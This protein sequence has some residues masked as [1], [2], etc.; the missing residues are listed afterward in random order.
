MVLSKQT[1]QRLF[2]AQKIKIAPFDQSLLGD[3]SYNLQL[4]DIAVY[5]D[6]G[7]E[8]RLGKD[9]HLLPGEFVL[10]NTKEYI[11]LPNYLIGHISSRS[12][13]ARLGLL[14]DFGAELIQPG[15]VGK[16]CLEI[17]NLSAKPVLL[18]PGLSIAQVYFEFIDSEEQGEGNPYQNDEKPEL[19]RLCQEIKM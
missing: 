4:D 6:T 16:I 15:H 5:P 2:N 8:K 12:S 17:K 18:Q 11:E 14:V 7:D 9:F 10:I 13:T 3:C 1:I 19:S